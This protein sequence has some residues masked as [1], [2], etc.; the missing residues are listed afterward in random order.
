MNE[1]Q[2]LLNAHR[3]SE[4]PSYHIQLDAFEGPL[5]LLLHLIRQSE[6]DVYD[7]PIAYITQQYLTHI[8]MMEELDL[9]V[10]GEFLVMASTLMHIKSKMLIPSPPADDE[11]EDQGQDP[12]EEL[13]KRLLN[14][15]KYKDAADKLDALPVLG[16]NVFVRK[17]RAHKQQLPKEKRELA[18]VSVFKLM[19]VFTQLI[20]QIE[21]DHSFHEIELEPISIMECAESIRESVL[22]SKEGSVPFIRLFRGPKS[23]LRVV[24]TFLAILDLIKRGYIRVFQADTFSTIEV[25]GT[26][27]IYQHW[28]YQGGDEYAG[29]GSN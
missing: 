14:Y 4:K 20:R 25:L 6:V 8:E 15:Q 10:A 22:E 29:P 3:D 2:P 21:R 11:D 27:Q 24:V 5:D 26:E 16:R 23:R 7:I 17:A 28:D 18:E 9:E 19:D 1:S 13:V 12:R